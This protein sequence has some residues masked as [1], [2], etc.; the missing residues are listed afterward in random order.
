MDEEGKGE[1]KHWEEIIVV[2]IVLFVV[3]QIF[4]SLPTFFSQN[5]SGS[6]G[7]ITRVFGITPP[8]NAN[9]PLGTAVLNT[10]ET[11]L[12]S[13]PGGGEILGTQPKGAK[14][15]TIGG[16]ILKDGELWW[17]VEYEDGGTGWVNQ[18]NLGIDLERDAKLIKENTPHG[19]KVEAV[20]G[21]KVYSTPDENGLVVGR[22]NPGDKG[23]IIGGPVERDGERWW[24]VRF[25]DGTSGW[26]RESALQVDVKANAEGINDNT[27][28]GTQIL[29]IENTNVWSSPRL[30]SIVGTQLEDAKGRL[31]DGSVTVGTT[32]WW[33][34]DFE[35]DPDGWVH[36]SDI[37]RRDP[38]KK[39]ASSGITFLKRLSYTI[40]LIL[41][42]GVVYVF[43]RLRRINKIEYHKYKPLSVV[44]QELQVKNDRWNR[45]LEHLDS[46][47]PNDWRLAILEADI[48]LDDIVE[49]M[50][51]PGDT[52][53]ERLKA[54]ERSDFETI[55]QAW[56]AH[57]VRNKL[58]HEG[59]DYVL[60]Q[61]EA[62]RVIN[63]YKQV[64]D[65]FHFI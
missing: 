8:L 13:E 53:G 24:Q 30:G 49:T 18:R 65:E 20:L 27:P 35:T 25:S 48:L 41:L 17:Q 61:R 58:A 38:L 55:D 57:K 5:S 45:V 2:F 11:T 16:P 52:L 43:T 3:L 42:V 33:D 47:S 12:F 22:I 28:L 14:G 23:V 54:V 64:F 60:T 1:S 31:I 7:F 44:P 21:S 46:G 26:V 34:V 15:I 50:Y 36:E 29:T 39:A 56:E 37:V 6:G 9:T 62:K 63:L 51:L 40:S 10:K 59:G 4:S 19:T 32:R